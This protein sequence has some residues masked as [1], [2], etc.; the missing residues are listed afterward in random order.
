VQDELNSTASPVSFCFLYEDGCSRQVDL[1]GVGETKLLSL[2]CEASHKLLSGRRS[3]P[4]FL[5]ELR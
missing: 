1:K 5:S 3:T 2:P 4:R